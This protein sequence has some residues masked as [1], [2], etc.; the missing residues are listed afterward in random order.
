MAFQFWR[1]YKDSTTISVRTHFFFLFCSLCLR[2]R[3]FSRR[4]FVQKSIPKS[5]QMKLRIGCLTETCSC[6]VF[7]LLNAAEH[8]E[9]LN[10]FKEWIR[11]CLWRLNLELK[12]FAQIVHSWSVGVSSTSI[13]PEN[14]IV[15][16]LNN[17]VALPN[18]IQTHYLNTHKHAHARTHIQ[19]LS[20][21]CVHA[22]AHSFKHCFVNILRQYII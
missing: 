4:V 1:L 8:L 9:Q 13:F 10:K 21:A 3:C 15:Y 17:Q 11:I 6:S 22:R 19:A 12:A 5:S 16:S 20:S 14:K 18:Y 7:S 2:I